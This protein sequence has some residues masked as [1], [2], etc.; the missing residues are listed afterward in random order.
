MQE[1]LVSVLASW[2]GRS[3]SQGSWLHSEHYLELDSKVSFCSRMKPLV[4]NPLRLNTEENRLVIVETE[5]EAFG[6]LGT[7]VPLTDRMTDRQTQLSAIT[8]CACAEG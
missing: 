5:F 4:D 2:G 7:A 1:S 3:Q 6:R 8:L